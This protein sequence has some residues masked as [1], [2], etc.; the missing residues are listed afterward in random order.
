MV[1]IMVW[2]ISVTLNN[3]SDT[4]ISWQSILLVEE[5]YVLTIFS[6]IRAP[7]NFQVQRVITPY[8]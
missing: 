6:L 5:R 4:G 1:D 8:F 7:D 3:F 2:E